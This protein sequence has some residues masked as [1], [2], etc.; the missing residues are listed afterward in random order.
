ML[1]V[2][3]IS[4]IMADHTFAS[5]NV[6]QI[7][8]RCSRLTGT[9]TANT[10]YIP[11]IYTGYHGVFIFVDNGKDTAGEIAAAYALADE[12]KTDKIYV[13]TPDDTDE[14]NLT[15]KDHSYPLSDAYYDPY[16][17]IANLCDHLWYAQ[18]PAFSDITEVAKDAKS[19]I[20]NKKQDKIADYLIN[21]IADGDKK[22]M[23][24]ADEDM[25]PAIRE[26]ILTGIDDWIAD[27]YND[28]IITGNY[29]QYPD[30]RLEVQKVARITTA[31][32][33]N[34]DDPLGHTAWYPCSPDDPDNMYLLTA[35]GGMIGA[36]KFKTGHIAQAI[37]YVLTCGGFGLFYITDLIAM[38]V[39]CYRITGVS[40][41]VKTVT[42]F[43]RAKDKKVY[44][45]AI[46]Y[47]GPV[48]D[49]IRAVVILPVT[50]VAAYIVMRFIYLPFLGLIF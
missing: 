6:P 41:D 3:R 36:H 38:V 22:Q 31:G 47:L 14:L 2:S 24:N 21:P 16:D 20:Q 11:L 17:M 18:F 33:I 37:L 34:M 13:I 40:E 1:D 43:G 49:K 50:A 46:S 39:G 32:G 23:D 25:I 27:K 15:Y 5:I 7:A 9:Q 29:R 35:I 26:D 48:K 45:E 30:G 12:L 28:P 44:H 10:Y 4:A 19:V 42:R 8:T